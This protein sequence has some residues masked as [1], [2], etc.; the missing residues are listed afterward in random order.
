MTLVKEVYW[1]DWLDAFALWYA[2]L[3]SY[4]YFFWSI[5]VRVIGILAGEFAVRAH[6]VWG[7]VLFTIYLREIW[8]GIL[9]YYI[10]INELNAYSLLRAWISL[11]IEAFTKLQKGFTSR[12]CPKSGAIWKLKGTML[13]SVLLDI[14]LGEVFRCLWILCYS[15]GAKCLLLVYFLS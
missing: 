8:V 10:A 5:G 12:Y 4:M 14:L 6:S 11:F 7:N 3:H 15:Y 13:I 9:I 1:N 2:V